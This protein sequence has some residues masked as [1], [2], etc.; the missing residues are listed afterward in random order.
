MASFLLLITKYTSEPNWTEWAGWGMAR[1]CYSTVTGRNCLR[2]ILGS[3]VIINTS[4][5]LQTSIISYLPPFGAV[6]FMQ[7]ARHPSSLSAS[8]PLDISIEP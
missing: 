4:E 7:E 1:I 6:Y 3:S 5:V 8:P 2:T